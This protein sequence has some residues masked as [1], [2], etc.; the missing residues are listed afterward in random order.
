MQPQI[1]KNC[2]NFIELQTTIIL[3][4]EF[5]QENINELENVHELYEFSE[6]ECYQIC[7]NEE[8]GRGKK[9]Q[10]FKKKRKNEKNLTME[11]LFHEYIIL[12][13]SFTN[14]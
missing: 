14:P 10:K 7:N 5:F 3:K 11:K 8:L 2:Y 6:L 12:Q 1:Q 4:S 13:V 9:V